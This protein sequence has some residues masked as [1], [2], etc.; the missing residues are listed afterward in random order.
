MNN[1]SEKNTAGMPQFMTTEFMLSE[2]KRH[3]WASRPLPT[4]FKTQQASKKQAKPHIRH[5]THLL[6]AALLN[7]FCMPQMGFWYKCIINTQ[8]AW[9]HAM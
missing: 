7:R 9:G 3:P 1:K 5:F 8:T 4:I 2:S 6:H